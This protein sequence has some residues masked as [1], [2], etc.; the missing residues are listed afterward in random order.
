MIVDI[1]TQ[2][3]NYYNEDNTFSQDEIGM[4]VEKYVCPVCY[5]Q[6]VVVW[7]PNLDDRVLITCPE[8]GNVCQIGRITHA[9][10]SIQ[11]DNAYRNFHKVIRNLPDLWGDLINQG[12]ERTQAGKITQHSVCEVCGGRL[13]MQSRPDYPHMNVVDIVCSSRHGNINDTG[14]VRREE[15]VYD[16]QRIRAWEKK[17]R[18]DKDTPK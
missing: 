16:F 5:G 18:E 12:F 1:P 13:I 3:A 9:T 4:V 14:Y 7:I 6:L 17:I 11:S 10:V 8:H 15:F 2:L